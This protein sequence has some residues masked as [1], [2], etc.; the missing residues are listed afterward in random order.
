M[1]TGTIFVAGVRIFDTAKLTQWPVG[2]S[3][4]AVATTYGD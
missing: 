1:G 3:N 2:L 4:R